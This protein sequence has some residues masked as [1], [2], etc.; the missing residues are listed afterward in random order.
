MPVRCSTLVVLIVGITGQPRVV[1]GPEP[2]GR[3]DSGA[4]PQLRERV[5]VLV[6]QQGHHAPRLHGRR[7]LKAY[8]Q[9]RGLHVLRGTRVQ[10]RRIAA[11]QGPRCSG[12]HVAAQHDLRWR[13]R[14]KGGGLRERQVEVQAEAE[15]EAG[16]S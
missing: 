8:G 15:E 4:L 5:K 14:P 6:Q 16:R 13:L 7:L 9:D 3:G 1:K 12:V 11:G 10:L 2:H